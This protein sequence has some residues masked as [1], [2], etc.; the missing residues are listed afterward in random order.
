MILTRKQSFG[1][2]SDFLTCFCL[3][4]EKFVIKMVFRNKSSVSWYLNTVKIL[5]I[6]TV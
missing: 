2:Y 5:K 4:Y 6:N 1:L 3:H